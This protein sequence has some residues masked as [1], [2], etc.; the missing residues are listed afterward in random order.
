MCA[1]VDLDYKRNVEVFVFLCRQELLMFLSLV[2]F[3]ASEV[4][5]VYGP[6]RAGIRSLRHTY[7]ALYGEPV[8]LTSDSSPAQKPI[9]A[10]SLA[11][12][13][14]II[15]SPRS[16]HKAAFLMSAFEAAQGDGWFLAS[17][18]QEP[19]W[20][21]AL[22]LRLA[23]QYVSQKPQ[24]H[25]SGSRWKMWVWYSWEKKEKKKKEEEVG[26]TGRLRFPEVLEMLDSLWSTAAFLNIT[27][28]SLNDSITHSNL[29][30][31]IFSSQECIDMRWWMVNKKLPSIKLVQVCMAAGNKYTDNVSQ[32]LNEPA[33][34]SQHGSLVLPNIHDTFASLP[35]Y[36]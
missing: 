17:G 29:N 31:N 5:L 34:W 8:R 15:W 21:S 9:T 6:P 32:G 25:I 1:S 12:A 23:S 19:V 36:F 22:F 2:S 7:G 27:V 28:R 24:L 14:S 3:S 35:F 10:V 20:N 26:T 4:N 11:L 18:F 13:K 16:I 33:H 30:I